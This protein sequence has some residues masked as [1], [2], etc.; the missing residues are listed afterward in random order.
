MVM[1]AKAGNI[2]WMFAAATAFTCLLASRSHDTSI[3]DTT[4]RHY[5]YRQFVPTRVVQ[6][7][8]VHVHL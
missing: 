5:Q 1:I 4:R 3:P 7:P 6:A 8:N 2:E